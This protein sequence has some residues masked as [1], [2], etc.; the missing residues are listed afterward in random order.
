M[1]PRI[2]WRDLQDYFG[3]SEYEAKAYEFLVGEGPSTARRISVACGIPRTKIYE[4]LKKLIE[5]EMII[6]VPVNPKRFAALPPSEV[7]RPILK[8]QKMAIRRFN[9]IVWSLQKRYERTISLTSMLRGEFWLFLG[10]DTIKGVSDV[11]SKARREIVTLLSWGSFAQF[12]NVF[13]RLLDGLVERGVKV[14]VCFSADS[15]IDRRI[16]RNIGLNY[17]VVNIN[18]S[19]SIIFLRVDDEYLIVYVPLRS[20]GLTNGDGVAVLLKNRI[21]SSLL[22]EVLW[23]PS[24]LEGRGQSINH[25]MG[26]APPAAHQ[27]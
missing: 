1:S 19:S 23:G 4:T 10:S 2:F 14:Q 22:D 18:L 27:H 11:L 16:C 5:Y 3:L 20:S 12:Y 25:L 17:K 6:E 13:G 7:L 26:L 15:E 24:Q 21:L 8:L 9:E